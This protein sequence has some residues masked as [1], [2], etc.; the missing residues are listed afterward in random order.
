MLRYCTVLIATGILLIHIVSGA[1]LIQRSSAS[2]EL[3]T[4][5]K[6]FRH[7]LKGIPDKDERRIARVFLMKR[8]AGVRKIFCSGV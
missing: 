6:I 8:I 7:G 2:A 5:M 1:K 4:L 3:N